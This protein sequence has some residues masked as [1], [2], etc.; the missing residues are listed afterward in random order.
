VLGHL[1]RADPLLFCAAIA[2]ATATFPLRALRWRVILRARDGAPFPLRPLW[3]ATA[4]GFMANNLL[5][6]RAGEVTRAYLAAQQLPVAFTTALA[7]IAVERVFD[8]L[9]M[10]GLLTVALAAP[11]FP[12]AAVVGG[13]SLSDLAGWA[14]ALFGAALLVAL[15]VVH[16]PTWWLGRFARLTGAVL[17]PGRAARLT[18]LAES[19]LAGLAVLKSPGRFATVVGWSLAL[20]VVNA[21]SFVVCFRAFGLHVPS[22]GA[23]VLQGLIGFGVALPSSPGFFGPFEAVTR[24]TLGFYGI[25][26]DQAVSYAV[27]YHLGG[28]LPI[29]VLGLHSLSRSHLRLGELRQVETAVEP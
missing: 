16:R 4:A 6:A 21:L 13:I 9:T 14:A 1:R 10:V 18:Q 20:W 8:G 17:S 2:L 26:A 29:T 19:L 24:V 28:F 23:F 12:R 15:L 27:A 3:H 25:A 22:L 11:S 5:P 7:S